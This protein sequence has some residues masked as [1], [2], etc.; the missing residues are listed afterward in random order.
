MFQPV[1]LDRL[2][3]QELRATRAAA[4]HQR[5]DARQQL[6]ELE[7]LREVVV[8]AGIEPA[9]DVLGRVACRE[10][11]DRRLATLA[12]Q[13]RRHLQAV[14][15]GEHHVEHHEIVVVDMSERGGLFTVGCD[16]HGVSFFPQ[17]LLDKAGDFAI[18]FHH[19]DFHMAGSLGVRR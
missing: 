9:H 15:L 8:G 17:A 18:V 10:H 7:R 19:E 6:V 3:G 14:L 11:Q 12:P 13:L 16:V 1:Q 4:P 5:P 2:I